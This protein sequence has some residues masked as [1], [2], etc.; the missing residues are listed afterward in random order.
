[1]HVNVKAC[2]FFVIKYIRDYISLNGMRSLAREI[3]KHINM[4]THKYTRISRDFLKSNGNA[5][6]TSLKSIYKEARHISSKEKMFGHEDIKWLWR[7]I[8]A[9]MNLFSLF[10]NGVT[11]RK[12]RGRTDVCI[13]SVDEKHHSC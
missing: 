11:G 1:M 5:L 13:I 9:L 3:K 2:T 7:H 8:D 12:Q 6:K 4:S 10:F